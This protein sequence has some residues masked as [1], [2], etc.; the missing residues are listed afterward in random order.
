MATRQT[1]AIHAN[2][3]MQH[4]VKF[5]LAIQSGLAKQ[6]LA[7]FITDVDGEA[8]IHVC[9]GPHYALR[10]HVKKPRVLYIDRAYWGDP[11][12]VSI[13]WLIDGEKHRSRHDEKRAHPELAE[14]KSGDRVIYLLAHGEKS[15]PIPDPFGAGMTI[16][17]HP[18]N[19]RTS[20]SLDAALERHEWAVGGRTTA[21][22]SAA[23]S[24]LRVDTLDVGSP[25]YEIRGGGDRV[26][27]INNMAWH[28]WSLEEIKSGDFYNVFK[29]NEGT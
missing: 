9:I 17:H 14:Y 29:R 25:V 12:S 20:E 5:A 13:H 27:W 16:R 21:L 7:P 4:Q 19:R 2:R 18:A 22:V 8:D 6:G 23:I 10:Q 28:N 24:G 26:P 1:V 15:A 11:E 3:S